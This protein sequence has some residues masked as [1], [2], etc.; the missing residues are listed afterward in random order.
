MR[1]LDPLK[2]IFAGDASG[3]IFVDNEAG[4]KEAV[5]KEGY[6]VYFRDIFGGDFGHCTKKGNWLLAENIA[7]AILKDYLKQ[8]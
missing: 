5:R 6:S 8:R 7:N 4:F 3:I 2:R 1:S